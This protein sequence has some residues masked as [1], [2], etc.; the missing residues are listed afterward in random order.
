MD[1]PI[2]ILLI[3]DDE[4]LFIIYGNLLKQKLEYPFIFDN[5]LSS[6]SLEKI[7]SEK[8]Y[9]LIILDQKLNN[10]IKGIDLIPM[11][12]KDNLCAYIIMNSA[13]GSEKLA[14]DAMR[15]GVNDYVD[16]NK[17]NNQSLMLII[18]KGIEMISKVDDIEILSQKMKEFS[19]KINS[20]SE[21][22]L[23]NTKMKCAKMEA[24]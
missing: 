14:I 18:E 1:R 23:N 7:L 20:M 4:N 11:I 24:K 22:N 6:E 3:D 10:G 12:K 9:D 15:N 17:E 2:N 16:G 13:Y 5:C 21:E 19:K 8:K